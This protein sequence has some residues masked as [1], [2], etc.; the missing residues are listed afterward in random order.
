MNLLRIALL[1]LL[2]PAVPPPQA[3]ATASVEGIVV[4]LGTADPVS[5]ADVDIE[6]AFLIAE[7]APEMEVLEALRVGE[8]REGHAVYPVDHS[9]AA[10]Q[11]RARNP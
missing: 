7:A 4:R 10:R 8:G 1:L 9:G 2:A 3:P 5:G 11:R 6:P